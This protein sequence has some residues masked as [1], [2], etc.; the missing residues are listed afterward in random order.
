LNDAGLLQANIGLRLSQFMS[1]VVAIPESRRCRARARQCRTIAE[2]LH[3]Q[4]A[5]HHMLKAAADYE[6]MANDAE[7]REIALGLS[8]LRE[9]ATGEQVT[10]LA[11]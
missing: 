11:D 1:P 9:L 6:R 4:I 5:R 7:Q 2:Q 8:H 3:G 10:S